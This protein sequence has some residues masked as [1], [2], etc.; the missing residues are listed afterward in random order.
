MT[1]RGQTVT[2]FLTALIIVLSGNALLPWVA[3]ADDYQFVTETGE[4]RTIEGSLY[5]TGQ[6]AIAVQL[7]D[8]S[9]EL[10]PEAAVRRRVPA[11]APEPIGPAEMLTRLTE[12]FG[13]DVFRGTV[14]GPY[15]IGVVL[16]APLPKT[17]ERLVQGNLRRSAR[18]MKSIEVMFSSFCSSMRVP[19]LKPE[20]PLVVLIFETD[21]DFEE[22]TAKATGGRGLS[23]GNIA[24]FYSPVTNYLYVRM[25]ECYSF[26]TPLHEAIHQQCFNTGVLQRLAPI[27]TWFGEGIATGFEGSGDKVKSDPQKLNAVYAKLLQRMGRLPNGMEWDDV[28]QTDQVFRGDIFAGEAYLH[29]WS[30]HWLLVSKYRKQYGEFLTHL[31]TLEPLAPE[32]PKKRI[33]KFEDVFG[34]SPNDIQAEFAGAFEGALRRQRLPVDPEQRPGLMS[35]QT[36]LAGIDMYVESRGAVMQVEG[37]LRNLSPFRDMAYLVTLTTEAGTSQS[38]YLPKLKS[39]ALVPLETKTLPGFGARTFGVEVQSTPADSE[40]SKRW[41]RGEFT[42]PRRR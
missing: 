40:E 30:M 22:Y 7:A 14:E 12:E 8:G 15:V 4:T 23:A 24:G 19:V 41:S 5:A 26:S 42:L 37:Q 27:P 25:S 32:E 34:K 35:R 6:G 36:N 21:N 39:N 9:L 17:S 31:S 1:H 16:T 33:A 29:A 10:I 38:W 28:V 2:S 20:F 18:Y 11:E 3:V 13:E